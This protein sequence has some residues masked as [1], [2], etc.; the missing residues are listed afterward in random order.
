MEFSHADKRNTKT[1]Q[2][3]IASHDFC[4]FKEI[5]DLVR[6]FVRAGSTLQS[7]FLTSEKNAK[8]FFCI[9]ENTS[10]EI[11]QHNELGVCWKR[12]ESGFSFD[13]SR[14]GA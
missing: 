9:L 11:N 14:P 3:N 2:Q 7:A 4:Y 5:L 8:H 12:R 1:M 6:I 13:N 10:P